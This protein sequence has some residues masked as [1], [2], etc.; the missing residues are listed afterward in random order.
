MIEIHQVNA[1]THK[2]Y[3]TLGNPA[4]VVISDHL[5][6]VGTMSEIAIHAGL[7]ITAFVVRDREEPTDITLRYYDLTGRECHICGHATVATTQILIEQFPDLIGKELTFH[8]NPALFEMKENNI[9]TT[10]AHDGNISIT[11]PGSDLVS[12][13][14]DP[15]LR[16]RIAKELGTSQELMVSAQSDDP[17]WDLK[18]R[19][20]L[21][22]TGVNEDIACGSGNCSIIPFW[23]NRGLNSHVPSYRS[24]FPYPPHPEKLGGIQFVRYDP[25]QNNVTIAAEATVI[26]SQRYPLCRQDRKSH[27]AKA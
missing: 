10:A 25:E 16:Q 27:Q 2:D 18:V 4:G 1:F 14:N 23:Y 21:P 11:L 17:V 22:I 12:C 5:L 26:G 9:R 8:L 3:P 6:S 24:V 15:I 20:F 13:D 19:V 7:P